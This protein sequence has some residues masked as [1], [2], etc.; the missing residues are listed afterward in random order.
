MH[1]DQLKHLVSVPN[2]KVYRT[3]NLRDTIPVQCVGLVY[4]TDRGSH[5]YYVHL[6]FVSKSVLF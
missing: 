4:L 6:P 5:K 2:R 3:L 1:S